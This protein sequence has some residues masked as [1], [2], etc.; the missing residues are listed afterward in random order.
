MFLFAIGDTPTMT[1]KMDGTVLERFVASVLVRREKHV[2]PQIVN[3]IRLYHGVCHTLGI[4]ITIGQGCMEDL[5]GMA[6]SV[7]QSQI[8]SPWGNRYLV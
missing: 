6:S 1:R 5:N 4:V 8:L 2:I 7:P 3:I